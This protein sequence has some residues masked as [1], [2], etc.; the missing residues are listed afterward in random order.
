MNIKWDNPFGYPNHVLTPLSTFLNNNS[1]MCNKEFGMDST[2]KSMDSILAPMA[3]TLASKTLSSRWYLTIITLLFFL[4]KTLMLPLIAYTK[5]AQQIELCENSLRCTTPDEKGLV[6]I[7]VMW[8]HTMVT[9]L[10]LSH[11]ITFQ[12]CACLSVLRL[13]L[14]KDFHNI[15]AYYVKI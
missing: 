6:F 2:F 7:V 3:S 1:L 5:K 9:P 14:L 12:G 13:K 15:F 4:K 11:C 8:K 10:G